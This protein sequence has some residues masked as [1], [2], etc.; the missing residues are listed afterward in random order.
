M[1]EMLLKYPPNKYVM[2]H[3]D[4]C[5]EKKDYG[6]MEANDREI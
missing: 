2:T 4:K 3:Y 5:Y 1:G 6:S